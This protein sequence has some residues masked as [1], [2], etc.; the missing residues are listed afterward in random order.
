[1]PYRDRGCQLFRIS[2]SSPHTTRRSFLHFPQ[3]PFT[4]TV[5]SHTLS[6]ITPPSHASSTCAIVAEVNLSFLRSPIAEAWARTYVRPGDE[7]Q[8]RPIRPV[9]EVRR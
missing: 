9:L 7:G 2:L 6:V 1:M 5:H 3:V 8:V 4:L